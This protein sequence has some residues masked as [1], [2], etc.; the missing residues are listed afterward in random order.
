MITRLFLKTLPPLRFYIEMEVQVEQLA[1]QGVNPPLGKSADAVINGLFEQADERRLDFCGL[2][3]LDLR[4][5]LREA[6]EYPSIHA[7]I[8]FLQTLVHETAHNVAGD[9][10]CLVKSFLYTLLDA[11]I[12]LLCGLD[13]FHWTDAD[14]TKLI[15]N[16]LG[17]C[18]TT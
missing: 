4:L 17:L 8:T 2:K 5:S 3:Q 1:I 11:R 15:S 9:F 12:F 13:E 18:R 6:I 16:V 7:A 10:S 14:K